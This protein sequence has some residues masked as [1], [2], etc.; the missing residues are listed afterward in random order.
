MYSGNVLKFIKNRYICIDIV[1]L[2]NSGKIRKRD[3]R[4][5]FTYHFSSLNSYFDCMH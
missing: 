4:L 2:V 5:F 3:K 1:L